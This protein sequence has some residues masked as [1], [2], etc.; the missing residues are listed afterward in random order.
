MLE[1]EPWLHVNPTAVR[2]VRSD[3]SGA[4]GADLNFQGLVRA[5]ASEEI[6]LSASVDRRVAS[7]LN[8]GDA[9][10]EATLVLHAARGKDSFIV[11]NAKYG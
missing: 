2:F 5:G 8:R 11:V 3:L 9:Q 4:F 7:R 6:V 10:L 1:Y